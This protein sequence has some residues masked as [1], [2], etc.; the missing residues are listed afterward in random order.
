MKPVPFICLA[1]AF[2]A[3]CGRAEIPVAEEQEFL[4]SDVPTF[5]PALTDSA[6]TAVSQA[7]PKEVDV[8]FPLKRAQVTCDQWADTIQ[9]DTFRTLMNERHWLAFADTVA[10]NGVACV[11][12]LTEKFYDDEQRDSSI[13]VSAAPVDENASKD[14]G[15]RVVSVW[16]ADRTNQEVLL[17]ST[18]DS[19]RVSGF[20]SVTERPNA[21]GRRLRFEDSTRTYRAVFVRAD[22]K[23]RVDT[24]KERRN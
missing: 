20:V 18:I 3:A 13:S 19:T 4:E 2:A 9:G 6:S 7:L 15:T 23:W 21:L 11:E 14:S 24:L 8:R 17:L 10:E 16:V 22:G 12:S 5:S 1:I